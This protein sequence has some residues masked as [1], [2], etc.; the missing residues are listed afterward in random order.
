MVW[1]DGIRKVSFQRLPGNTPAMVHRASGHILFDPVKFAWIDRNFPAY[2]K[3]MKTFI[4]LHEWAHVALKSTDEKAVDNLAFQEYRKDPNRSHRAAVYALAFLLNKNNPEHVDRTRAQFGRAAQNDF[5]VNKNSKLSPFMHY[6]QELS[7]FNQEDFE[8]FRFG[9]K[10]RKRLNPFAIAQAALQKGADLSGRLSFE[11]ED[12][13]SSF[14]EYESFRKLNFKKLNPLQNNTVF[15]KAVKKLSG[16]ATMLPGVGGLA[17]T[18]VQGAFPKEAVKA[19]PV[20]AVEAANS[21]AAAAQVVNALAPSLSG[22]DQATAAAQVM[23]AT[24]PNQAAQVVED[25]KAKQKRKKWL[26]VGGI[27]AG[28][29]LLVI[30]IIWLAK[31]K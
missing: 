9:K 7:A 29:I 27:S 23:S 11:G 18:L 25:L 30:L 24:N 21:P 16:I 8:G 17:G 6:A 12:E 10:L 3:D 14:D 22:R 31:R 1:A 15:G 2:A 26:M 20:D 19:N 28:A 4:A 5:S 13:N